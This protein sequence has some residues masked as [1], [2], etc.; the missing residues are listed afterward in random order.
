[1]VTGSESVRRVCTNDSVYL[2]FP[3]P[4]HSKSKTRFSPTTDSF[5]DTWTFLQTMKKNIGKRPICE[6]AQNA[7]QIYTWI[8]ED[9]RTE[10][11][12]NSRRWAKIEY[13][14]VVP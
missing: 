6:R 7:M 12:Q 3:S 2:P 4:R 14:I 10:N 1:M 5:F 9:K 8:F 13:I 11:H